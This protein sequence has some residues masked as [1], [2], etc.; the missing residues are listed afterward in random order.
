MDYYREPIRYFHKSRLDQPAL[1][2]GSAHEEIELNYY[3][4]QVAEEEN[5]RYHDQDHS[6]LTKMTVV[7]IC[8]CK[9]FNLVA[10]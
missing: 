1:E 4:L 6:F 9:V 3:L 7:C 10:T 2:M 5:E 8:S